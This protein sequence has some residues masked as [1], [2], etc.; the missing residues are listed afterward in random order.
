MHSIH[1]RSVLL[2]GLGA[3]GAG[4]LSACGESTSTASSPSIV[5]PSGAPVAAAEEARTGTGETRK[6]GVTA[7]PAKVD[8]GA[9]SPPGPAEDHCESQQ[10]RPADR[11]E[12]QE[13]SVGLAEGHLAPGEAAERHS[14]A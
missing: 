8:L 11:G 4:L 6:F 5:S 9:A 3:A 10:R 1:R 2:A 12:G 7:A 14:C 13:P